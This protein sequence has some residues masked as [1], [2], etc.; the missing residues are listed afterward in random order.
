MSKMILESYIYSFLNEVMSYSDHEKINKVMSDLDKKLSQKTIN[1]KVVDLSS[2]NIDAKT[3]VKLRDYTSIAASKSVTRPV[4]YDDALYNK[5]KEI[6]DI[7]MKNPVGLGFNPFDI[8]SSKKMFYV[9]K[10]QKAVDYY[11]SEI[12][13]NSKFKDLYEEFLDIILKVWHLSACLSELNIEVLGA[14]IYRIALK[15]PGVENVVVKVALSNKSKQD[16]ISETEFSV[17]LGAPNVLYK[18]NFPR[19]YTYSTSGSNKPDGSWMAIEKVVMLTDL[20]NHP[21]ILQDVKEQFKNTFKLFKKSGLTK[22][23]NSSNLFIN[24]IGYMFDFDDNKIT[25]AHINAMNKKYPEFKDLIYKIKKLITGKKLRDEDH[26]SYMDISDSFFKTQMYS[27]LLA[28]YE[29]VIKYKSGNEIKDLIDEIEAGD[30]K[31]LLSVS[32]ELKLLFDQAV[33]TNISDTHVG[34]FGFMKNENNKWELVYTD[35]DSK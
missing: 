9:N 24:Y 13:K 14:G 32:N 23:I 11:E 2:L 34:N 25:A 1:G 8:L 6:S 5:S 16:N 4:S 15:I 30:D 27:F 31:H 28:M 19:V 21:E 10:F 35:I 17:G 26:I 22:L 3:L 7:D 33:T 18:S 29:E 20:K 12:N